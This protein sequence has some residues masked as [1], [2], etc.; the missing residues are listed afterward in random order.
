MDTKLNTSKK[1]AFTAKK[2][3]NLLGCIIKLREMII[4]LCSALVRYTCSSGSTSGLR[5]MNMRNERMNER[6]RDG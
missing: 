4:C 3:D 1:H 5:D 6:I 2:A